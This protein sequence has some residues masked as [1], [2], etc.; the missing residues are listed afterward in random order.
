MATKEEILNY[1]DNTPENSN[2]NVLSGMLDDYGG[3]GGA[4]IVVC[5]LTSEY[6]LGIEAFVYTAQMTAGELYAAES[7]VFELPQDVEQMRPNFKLPCLKANFFN[8]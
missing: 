7:I 2:R 8:G 5:P 6:D 4:N 1:V 3:S